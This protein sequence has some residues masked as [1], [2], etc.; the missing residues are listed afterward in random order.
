MPEEFVNEV[1]PLLQRPGFRCFYSLLEGNRETQGEAA[2]RPIT[3]GLFVRLEGI[4]R[5]AL[6]QVN[7]QAEGFS[8]SS[9]FE[10]VNSVRIPLRKD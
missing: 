4:A 2:V 8:W 9:D 1:R 6:I 5:D 10:P 7:V 3:G